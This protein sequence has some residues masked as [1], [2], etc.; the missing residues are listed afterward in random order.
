MLTFVANFILKPMVD[1]ASTHSDF[2]A[3]RDEPD[4]G[5][6]L[7][8]PGGMPIGDPGTSLAG[9]A[10]S[11][12]LLAE[13]ARTMPDEAQIWQGVNLPAGF[14]PMMVL[15]NNVLARARAVDPVLDDLI[16]AHEFGHTGAL[17]HTS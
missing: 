14:T 9:L 5:R 7:E 17:V 13:F 4:R 3:T 6:Q 15:G 16:A 8:R 12:A 10:I 2:G 11:P 1:F